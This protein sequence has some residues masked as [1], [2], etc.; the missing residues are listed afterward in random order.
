MKQNSIVGSVGLTKL[1]TEH[2]QLGQQ[3]DRKLI[4]L[5][6]FCRTRSSAP[7]PEGFYGAL[8]DEAE[9]LSNLKFR[10]WEK[11]Q[12]VAPYCP[13]TLD[14]NT[15]H[16]CLRLS[17]DLSGVH[18][19]GSGRTLPTNPERFCVSA[20]VLGST[21]I[22]SGTHAWE[23]ELGESDD[24]I[25]GV[26]SVS[27]KRDLEVPARPENGF[28]TLCMRDGEYR[29]MESPVR[30]LKVDKKLERVRVEVDWDTGEV[31]FSCP[32]DGQMLHRFEQVFT[33]KVVPYFY[34]QSE[35]PLRILPQLVMISV[36]N[37]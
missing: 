5:N 30:T 26:A 29:A 22:C 33:D 2:H 10:V 25:L 32:D 27:V 28:W 36:K 8:I 1:Y 31:C 18:Y 12:E 20:E 37:N 14:P 11:M 9:H 15:V 19:S 7:N 13:V 34:T 16:P 3:T 17:E 6:I 23:V 21:D 35:K 4:L 24:W